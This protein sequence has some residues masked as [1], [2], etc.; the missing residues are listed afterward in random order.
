M[1]IIDAKYAAGHMHICENIVCVAYVS[2]NWPTK[3]IFRAL[4]NPVGRDIYIA[5][6]KGGLGYANN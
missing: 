4:E 5:R 3:A 6:V 1:L 2:A